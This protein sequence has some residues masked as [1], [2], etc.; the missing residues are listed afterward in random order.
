L[1]AFSV[2][3][4]GRWVYEGSELKAVQNMKS[5]SKCDYTVQL[6]CGL[7]PIIAVESPP[8]GCDLLMGC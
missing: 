5:V 6:P 3:K 2:A 7:V 1:C 4:R 8:G